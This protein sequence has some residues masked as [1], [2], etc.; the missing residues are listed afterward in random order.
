MWTVF[1]KEARDLIRDRR[2]LLFL[3][4]VPLVVP[5]LGAAAGV[6]VLWQIARQAGDGIPIV[7]VNGEQLPGL[8]AELEAS[9]AL[10]IVDMPSNPEQ[11][12][13]AGD[14]VAIL[15]I[16]PDAAARM[17]A[18]QPITLHLT[19]SRN[20]WL[21]DFAVLAIQS[22]MSRYGDQVVA[23][24]LSQRALGP[25]WLE[26]FSLKREAATPTG[27]AIIPIGPDENAPSSLASAFLPMVIA[28]WALGGGLS[29]MAPM[30][31][32]EKEHRT[33]ESLLVT[34]ASRIGIVLGKVALS[35]VVSAI[36]IGLWSLDSL[37]YVLLVSAA[38]DGAGGLASSFGF[39]MG[40]LSRVTLWLLLL[41]LPFM[42]MVN[43]LV[44]AICTFA[45]NYRESGLFLT[46]LQLSLP[47]LALLAA[48]GFDARP[49]LVVYA[50]PAMGVLVALRDLFGG[51]IAPGALA[52]AWGAAAV[53]AAGTV[54]LAAYVFSRE[55]ALMRGV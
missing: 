48:F 39:Q 13:Q 43:G 3:F 11:A 30:T 53:Y 6:F 31:V 55:W 15:E 28:S 46:L 50:L 2:A 41:M 36:T 42:T 44:A 29:L 45:K 1:A 5:L 38:P 32:G 23:E 27:V 34:P 7:V 52:L 8:V 54:L 37:G 22:A 20:G 4:A 9:A 25:E 24:R 19:S 10:E 40:D 47:G 35:V 26:P 49:S 21:P 16:P 33:M 12:L 18:E 51:G 14:L 17:D